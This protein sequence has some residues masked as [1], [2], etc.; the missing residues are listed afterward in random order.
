MNKLFKIN[1]AAWTVLAV[2]V[3]FCGDLANNY[4][5][6]SILGNDQIVT[7]ILNV[8]GASFSIARLVARGKSISRHDL[9]VA[10]PALVTCFN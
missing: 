9:A 5:L 4:V 2:M 6:S 7:Q 1:L 8:A 3:A 10:L